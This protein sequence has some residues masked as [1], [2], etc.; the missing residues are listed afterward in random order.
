[1]DVYPI[2]AY[3]SSFAEGSSKS[4]LPINAGESE[5]NYKIEVEFEIR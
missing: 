2:A 1:M 4:S 3:D 5:Y